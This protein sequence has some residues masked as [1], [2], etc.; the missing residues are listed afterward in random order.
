VLTRVSFQ[1]A[2][3]PEAIRSPT[4]DLPRVY[5]VLA[6]SSGR[7]NTSIK[8]FGWDFD[9]QSLARPF[10]ELARHSVEVCLRVHRQFGS[11][12]KVLPQQAIGILIGS[13]LPWTLRITKI[14][15]DAGRQREP[16]MIRKL[17]AAVPG[18]RLIQLVRYCPSHNASA[19]R[20]GSRCSC[21]S[22][23][24]IDRLPNDLELPDPQP[25]PVAYGSTPNPLFTRACRLSASVDALSALTEDG[26]Q[27]LSS[28]LHGLE[29]NKLR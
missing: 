28:A 18:Q 10:I 16:P 29:Y 13:T 23:R 3:T 5:F 7:C 12:R 24:T 27:A 26:E 20:P 22:T 25:S 2:E 17:L 8:S 11:L 9:A 19:V 15:V 6:G 1:Y 14:D 4:P 21:C